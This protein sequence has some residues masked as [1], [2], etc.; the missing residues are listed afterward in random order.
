MA[1]LFGFI[2]SELHCLP[3]FP[4]NFKAIVRKILMHIWRHHYFINSCKF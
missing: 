4:V 3:S 2:P 1:A